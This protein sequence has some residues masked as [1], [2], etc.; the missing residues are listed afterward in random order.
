MFNSTLRGIP[1][2]AA[3]VMALVV[4]GCA[5]NDDRVAELERELAQMTAERD[6]LRQQRD[7]LAA[8]LDERNDDDTA[9]DDT[10]ADDAASEDDAVGDDDPNKGDDVTRPSAAMER[11]EEGLVDQIRMLLDW[12]ALPQGWEP[13]STPWRSFDLPEDVMGIYAE[14]GLFVIDLARV[15]DGP[16][17]GLEVWESTVRVLPGD[18]DDRATVAVLSWGFADDSVR[19]QDVRVEMTRIDGAWS[20][21]EAEVRYHCLRGVSGDLCV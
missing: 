18:D 13:G 1:V 11:S 17:L 12:G 7:E 21:D 8:T 10:P 4:A 15:L 20:A 19:G 2:T 6:D 5:S 9:A 16:M 3:A 14:P